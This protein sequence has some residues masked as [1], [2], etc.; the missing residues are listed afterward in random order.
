M[1]QTMTP[2]L[3]STRMKNK[4]LEYCCNNVVLCS[5]CRLHHAHST[6][7]H[8][9]KTIQTYRKYFLRPSPRSLITQ[10]HIPMVL[11]DTNQVTWCCI[12]TVILITLGNQKRE[13][14]WAVIIFWDQDHNTIFKQPKNPMDNGPH[15]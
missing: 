3:S 10:W 7:N 1:Y 9:R 6:Q 5:G 11:L 14:E 12:Y 4:I 2:P 13:A 15:Q 8:C